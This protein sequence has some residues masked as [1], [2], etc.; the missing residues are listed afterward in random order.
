M[1]TPALRS[2]F[3]SGGFYHVFLER[4]GTI[5][6]LP[7]FGVGF[8]VRIDSIGIKYFGKCSALW[9]EIEKVHIGQYPNTGDSIIFYKKNKKG[10]IKPF[11]VLRYQPEIMHVVKKYCKIDVTKQDAD[12][13]LQRD[14]RKIARVPYWASFVLTFV[15]MIFI[16]IV[17][18]ALD[19]SDKAKDSNTTEFTAKITKITSPPGLK[20]SVEGHKASLG[21]PNTVDLDLILALN[22]DD[23]ITFRVLTSN[24]EYL[25][26][27]T[28]WVGVASLWFNG[29]QLVSYTQF[30]SARQKAINE[31]LAIWLPITIATALV[32]IGLSIY[33]SKKRKK[34]I[35]GNSNVTSSL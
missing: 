21:I 15:C 6:L 24:V 35:A 8:G 9:S 22:I 23:E 4:E 25:D 31:H 3:K 17:F 29:T 12:M 11:V 7:R 34:W 19:I 20:I 13:Q 16:V 5:E 1:D 28:E 18:A 26:D 10:K 2:N 33:A 14:S 30:N 27:K 32:T